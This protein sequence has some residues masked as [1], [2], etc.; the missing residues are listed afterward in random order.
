[1][2]NF[3]YALTAAALL[4]V[5]PA[6]AQVPSYGPFP[7]QP[8]TFSASFTGLAVPQTAAMDTLCLVGSATKTIK[9]QRVSFSGIKT[10][11]QSANVNLV[12]RSAAST[13]GSSTSATVVP[14]D[15]TDAAGTAVLKGYTVAS[16]PGAGAV[17]RSAAAGFGP[18]TAGPSAAVTWTFD[19][20][21]IQQAIVLR[22]VAQQLCVNIPAALTT[23]GVALDADFTWTEQ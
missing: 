16:T 2:K 4:I 20:S 7:P 11:L 6:L 21:Q 19:I 23:D 22:G 15:S 1:M 14:L 12:K 3:A 17:I 9:V 5:S 13:G 10:T 8:P 18:G